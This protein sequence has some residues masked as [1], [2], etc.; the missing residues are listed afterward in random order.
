M[1]KLR[2][3]TKLLAIGVVAVAGDA[4]R[5]HRSGDR[6]QEAEPSR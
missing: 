4:V 1:R 2:T 5:G 3:T 6:S